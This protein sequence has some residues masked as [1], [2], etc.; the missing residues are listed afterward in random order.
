M[1]K[2]QEDPSV[3]SFGTGSCMHRAEFSASVFHSFSASGAICRQITSLESVTT[4]RIQRTPRFQN[5]NCL[6]AQR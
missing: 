2:R 6:E 4:D 3:T 5:N 1:T